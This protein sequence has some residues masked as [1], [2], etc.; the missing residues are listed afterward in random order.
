[1]HFDT[2]SRR[3]WGEYQFAATQDLPCQGTYGSSKDQR[4]DLKQVVLSTLCVERAVPIW[5]KPE[6]G[7]ASDQT[8]TATL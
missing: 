7:K 2:T 3:V 8:L 6:D 1:M 5:G 4:P